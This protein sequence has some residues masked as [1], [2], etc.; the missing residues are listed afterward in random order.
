M[1]PNAPML[2]LFFK[3]MLN[4]NH[5]I[6]MPCLHV[7][8]NTWKDTLGRTSELCNYDNWYWHWIMGNPMKGFSKSP[9]FSL[10][11]FQRHHNG[12]DGVSNHRRLDFYLTVCSCADQRK[13]QNSA[14]LAFLRGIHRWPVNS[15]QR[16][17]NTENA[18]IWWRHHIHTYFYMHQFSNPRSQTLYIRSSNC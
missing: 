1:C 10:P 2:H 8:I 16:A 15:S 18:C 11:T 5:I 12:R 9:Q 17:S 14:S 13:Q 4:Q 3:T 7:L 6:S